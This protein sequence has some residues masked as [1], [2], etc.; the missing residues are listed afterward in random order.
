MNSKDPDSD[1]S[2]V[3]EN[4]KGK[5]KLH[6][7]QW[8]IGVSKVQ[9]CKIDFKTQILALFNEVLAKILTK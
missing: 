2:G 1:D 8:F 6:N 5:L 4:D 3:D 7:S 9:I